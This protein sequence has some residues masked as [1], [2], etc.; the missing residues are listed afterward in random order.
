M[1]ATLFDGWPSG[2]LSPRGHPSQRRGFGNR[3]NTPAA[4]RTG[5]GLYYGWSGYEA[6]EDAFPSCKVGISGIRHT[7][8]QPEIGPARAS[9][10]ALRG[11]MTHASVPASTPRLV[12]HR[13][14]LSPMA[15]VTLCSATFRQAARHAG[16]SNRS[17][18]AA[19]GGLAALPR[20]VLQ[21]PTVGGATDG[22][23]ATRK[24]QSNH[25]LAVSSRQLV[26]K[27][28]SR[29]LGHIHAHSCT[30]VGDSSLRC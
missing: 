21:G 24:E 19:Q 6:L 14:D 4:Q 30:K 28:R 16:S 9:L 22:W 8:R 11:L 27:G 2:L 25:R 29:A 5:P 7:L 23:G 13:S 15:S 10:P 12:E 1:E 26:P 17:S 3:V 18:R 20:L